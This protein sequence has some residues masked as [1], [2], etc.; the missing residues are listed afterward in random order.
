STYTLG[1]IIMVIILQ[2]MMQL[3][4]G[5]MI[6]QELR[7]CSS[8]LIMLLYSG[9]TNLVLN[10]EEAPIVFGILHLPNSNY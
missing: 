5:Y 4:N 9:L 10:Q 8:V 7:I 1:I 6:Q 3:P 2:D